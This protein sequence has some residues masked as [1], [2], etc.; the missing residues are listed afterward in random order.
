MAEMTEYQRGIQDGRNI[1]A[2]LTCGRAR[3]AYDDLCAAGFKANADAMQAEISR[4]QAIV[5]HACEASMDSG[6]AREAAEATVA[7]L[8][9][10]CEALRRDAL[11]YRWLRERPVTFTNPVQCRPGWYTERRVQGIDLDAS[12]DGMPELRALLEGGAGA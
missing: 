9:E 10:E 3:T 1:D 11:R 4:L 5:C 6:H 12:I 2:Q 8:R 7:R